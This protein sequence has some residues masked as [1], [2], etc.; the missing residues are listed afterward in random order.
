MNKE[1]REY[2]ENN[3]LPQYNKNEKAHS[4][5][6]IK[7]VINRSFD[8]VK[9]NNLEVNLDIVYTVAAYHDI[10]YSINPK[11]HEIE[12]GKIMY[13]DSNLK[14]YFNE[15]ELLIIKEAIE[16]H[17][18]SKKEEPRSI[19]GKIVSSADRNNSIEQCLYRTYFYGKKLDSSAT[20][21]EL[22]ERAHT[23]LTNKFGEN[24]YAKYY[25]KDKKYE[26][27]LEDI[28][29]LL[30]DKDKFIKTQKDYINKLREEGKI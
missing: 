30:K 8:L 18:S 27:F 6:H 15:D 17:R 11:N 9:E 16:D 4:I 14:R 2:I 28:R 25:F 20:D 5:T 22:F 24:G 12:S 13:R 23:V 10:G 26:K 3:I 29:K 7:D 1:L 19:Y 21:M